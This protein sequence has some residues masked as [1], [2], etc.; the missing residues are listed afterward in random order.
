M[1][2]VVHCFQLATFIH[3]ALEVPW[4]E[5]GG[6]EMFKWQLLSML[7]SGDQ[8]TVDQLL[9][10]D[11]FGREIVQDEDLVDASS[12]GT[13]WCVIQEGE[14]TIPRCSQALTG[15]SKPLLQPIH[16]VM[17][18]VQLCQYCMMC[19]GSARSRPA[20]LQSFSCQRDGLLDMGLASDALVV[21]KIN[22]MESEE[23]VRRAFAEHSPLRVFF[24]S[25]LLRQAIAQ[26]LPGTS[27]EE[28]LQGFRRRVEG[29]MKTVAVFEDPAQ[30]AEAL[31]Q[32]DFPAVLG[33]FLQEQQAQAAQQTDRGDT[34]LLLLA[35]M[36]WFKGDFFKWLNQP[37]CPNAS[38]SSGV[39][40]QH[41][42]QYTRT[43]TPS[44][45]E[46]VGW[47]S[48]VE[49]YR[50]TA[51]GCGGEARF[52]RNNNP[53]HM[54]RDRAARRGR[55]GEFANAFGLI[56][57][58]LGID[59]RYVLDWTDH[60][61]LE[62]Y[63]P[64]HPNNSS[65]SR[66]RDS[67]D[68]VLHLDPCERALDAPLVYETGWKKALTHV[69]AVS[70][71]GVWDVLP[72]YSRRTPEV[73]Q[74]RDR[75]VLPEALA[76][77]VIREADGRALAAY[78]STNAI[79]AVPLPM[80]D[81]TDRRTM[82]ERLALGAAG[83]ASSSSAALGPAAV[84][85]RRR[86]T[87]REL[88]A[89]GFV[90]ST[91]AAASSTP[92]EAQ[93]RTSGDMAWR[94]QRGEV[95]DQ[96][97]TGTGTGVGDEDEQEALGITATISMLP[98]A[99][100]ALLNLRLSTDPS[101]CNTAVMPS[102]G[103]GK[104]KALLINRS[105]SVPLRRR[106]A[107][108]LLISSSGALLQ[109]SGAGDR[110]LLDMLKHREDVKG[111]WEQGSGLLVIEHEANAGDVFMSSLSALGLLQQQGVGG[112]QQ[113][114]LAAAFSRGAVLGQPV[115][116]IP[117]AHALPCSSSEGVAQLLPAFVSMD[118][119][120]AVEPF[121]STGTEG[122]ATEYDELLG[123]ACHAADSIWIA[124]GMG[125]DEVVAQAKQRM[126][127]SSDG[128]GFAVSA[129]P[130]ATALTHAVLFFSAHGHPLTA[131]PSSR[132][133][134]KRPAVVGGQLSISQSLCS[135]YYPLGGG[136]HADSLCFDTSSSSTSPSPFGP[137]DGAVAV[138]AGSHLVNG[139]EANGLTCTS[140]HDQPLR[141]TPVRALGLGSITGMAV[142]CGALVDRIELFSGDEQ[143]LAAGGSGGQRRQLSWPQGMQLTGFLGALGGHM[144]SIGIILSLPS[145]SRSSQA[146]PPA[147]AC[148]SALL[149]LAQR[150]AADDCRH[151]V[152]GLGPPSC[153]AH[154]GLLND[155]AH[156]HADPYRHIDLP[157]VIGRTAKVLQAADPATARACMDTILL[158]LRNIEQVH[159]L[160][161]MHASPLS[162]S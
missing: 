57:R 14:G 26:Q 134:L 20:S 130:S 59:V 150:G 15:Q 74:R 149:A 51:A 160:T 147:D 141:L 120:L 102:A 82:A 87:Q 137:A 45:A 92:E 79:Y 159:Q 115:A 53:A 103:K 80:D 36:R 98:C 97:S 75:E 86:V 109:V 76:A 4:E 50:C 2:V 88:Q 123:H 7:P 132:V 100:H 155:P 30:Q 148:S 11:G 54:L 78:L 5:D 31:A 63:I 85:H 101:A 16:N 21:D 52:P 37:P 157:L 27:S 140:F 32:I 91:S 6:L 89:I 126:A 3:R 129:L 133:Y 104:G 146:E 12:D 117:A 24:E 83:F 22:S 145:A 58:A 41:S 125:L 49:V 77:A 139:I 29:A 156:A 10:I 66:N 18:A 46:A 122:M 44:T 112:E 96:C 138:Y 55:C 28:A 25:R 136:Q 158:Y 1:E 121:S 105:L 116:L 56:C 143:V 35:L 84:A 23:A 154:C 111:A 110:G 8:T 68:R 72:R 71:Y 65:G 127:S 135:C 40:V 17:D 94:R 64:A 106:G 38:T 47:P 60:V 161:P 131:V 42:M 43:D 13:L 119:D 107:N 9:L 113:V 162:C 70:R 153:L 152:L 61:W 73:V 108:V 39:G 69:L 118:L 62:A 48:R 67:R 128:M 142:H 34:E 144:H 33:Y 93:G 99:G 114:L 19:Q 124:E 90:H 81:M 95:H 151:G